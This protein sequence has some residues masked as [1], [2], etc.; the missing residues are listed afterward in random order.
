MNYDHIQTWLESL[1][2]TRPPEVLAM[3]QYAAEHDFPIIDALSG[4]LCY[5]I[6][7]L[8]GARRIFELGSGYG[9]ST[10][11]FAQAAR[12]NS[13]GASGGEVHHTVWDENLSQMA[14][15]HLAALGYGDLVHFHVGEAVGIL[16]G[17]PGPFD[18]IF[19]D[20]DKLGYPDALPLIRERLR[21]GG[22]LIID[23][24]LWKGRLWNEADHDPETEAV[25]R[26]ART[27]AADPAWTQV[28]VPL[29]D[30]VLVARFNG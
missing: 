8:V 16:R 3:E 5:L 29:R 15:G 7:R 22:V 24:M 19:M 9:Y 13:A 1:L 23:N 10:A 17:I 27:I 18:L 26:T 14:R 30:G 4:N 21:P 12:E 2:P 11:W 6:A 25:R 20:I 28:T